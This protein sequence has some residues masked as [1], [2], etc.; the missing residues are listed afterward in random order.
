M[1]AVDLFNKKV[2]SAS[3]VSAERMFW[4]VAKKGEATCVAGLR[5]RA[6]TEAIVKEF[7]RRT[8]NGTETATLGVDTQRLSVKLDDDVSGQMAA[9]DPIRR[10]VAEGLDFILTVRHMSY[11]LDCNSYK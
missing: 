5:F 4:I 8:A 11:A 1:V 7:P 9:H 10:S 2:A 6:K 3:I